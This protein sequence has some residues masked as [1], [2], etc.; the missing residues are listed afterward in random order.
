MEE[1]GTMMNEEIK[2][3]DELD[4]LRYLYQVHSREHNS[5]SRDYNLH[6]MSKQMEKAVKKL[7]SILFTTASIR[8]QLSEDEFTESKMI[9]DEIFVKS[10]PNSGDLSLVEGKFQS[11]PHQNE[12]D[13][14]L[15]GMS[16]QFEEVSK[17]EL[18]GFSKLFQV[19]IDKENNFFRVLFNNFEKN[20]ESLKCLK[21]LLFLY[22]LSNCVDCV[23]PHLGDTRSPFDR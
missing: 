12:V 22:N 5:L 9:E 3:R 1:L 11:T 18:I 10:K 19:K 15:D 14:S 4:N 6:L 13:D 7:T 17:P 21:D 2:V 23:C 16:L 8:Q 20:F